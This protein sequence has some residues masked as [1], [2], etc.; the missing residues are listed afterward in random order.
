MNSIK[1][2]LRNGHQKKKKVTANNYNAKNFFIL[3]PISFLTAD[4]SYIIIIESNVKKYR[5]R[6]P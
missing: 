3:S 1:Q 6:R 5:R 4:N 2:N